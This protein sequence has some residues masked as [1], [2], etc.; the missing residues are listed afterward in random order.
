VALYWDSVTGAT[1]VVV[2]GE[3][4]PRVQVDVEPSAAFDA[5]RRPCAYAAAQGTPLPA[6]LAGQIAA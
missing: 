6:D 4:G 2:C 5:Y 1:G 3:R